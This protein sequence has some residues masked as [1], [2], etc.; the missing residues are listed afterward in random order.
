MSALVHRLPRL[1]QLFADLLIKEARDRQRRRRLRFVLVGIALVAALGAYGGFKWSGGAPSV[2][3]VEDHVAS[4][5]ERAGGTTILSYRTHLSGRNPSPVHGWRD[6]A[7][8]RSINLGHGP[9]GKLATIAEWYTRMPHSPLYTIH[10]VDLW[11]ASSTFVPQTFPSQ[12]LSDPIHR[13]GCDPFLK[14]RA[15]R[16]ETV[17]LGDERIDGQQTIHLRVTD[18]LMVPIR[19]GTKTANTFTTDIWVNSSTYLPVRLARRSNGHL[20]AT[21]DYKWLPRTKTNLARVSL[22]IPHGFEPISKR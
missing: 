10:E 21:T 8:G 14:T 6:L 9:A 17:L 12:T 3:Q 16:K 20:G 22:V 18:H 1:P 11:Y 7:T 2:Q 15:V 19:R 5:I 13:C 4:S